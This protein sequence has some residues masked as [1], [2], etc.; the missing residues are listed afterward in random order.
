LVEN[1]SYKAISRVI[2]K[3][4]GNQNSSQTKQIVH[5]IRSNFNGT[6]DLEYR[7]KREGGMGDDDR[8]VVRGFDTIKF[9]GSTTDNNHRGFQVYAKARFHNGAAGT[10]DD[11]LKFNERS[12][13]NSLNIIRQLN[14]L[15]YERSD[16]FNDASNLLYTEAGLIAQDI[17]EISDLSYCVIGGDYY[18]ISNNLIQ[19]AYAL[20]YNSIFIYNIAATKELDAIVQVQETKISNLE[21]ENTLLKSKLNE[22]LIEMGKATI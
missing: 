18:D 10:S 3:T 20:E 9:Y 19:N 4:L 8:Y 6:D 1:Q 7:I 15:I 11:R 17:L 14:P 21:A 2:A 22:I 13:N 12:I 16:N 5:Q